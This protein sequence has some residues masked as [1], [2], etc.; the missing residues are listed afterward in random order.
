MAGPR[1]CC[2]VPGCGKRLGPR[3]DMRVCKPHEHA[4]GFCWCP[5]CIGSGRA[6]RSARQDRPEV[7]YVSMVYAT[8]NGGVAGAVRV[9]LPREPWLRGSEG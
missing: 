9:S 6:P 8:G 4:E 7:R 3:I 1:D 2:V 5:Q